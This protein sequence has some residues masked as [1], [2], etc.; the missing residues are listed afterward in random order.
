MYYN[1]PKMS[2][3]L[4]KPSKV[5]V[6]GEM[7][8][9]H[10]GSSVNN[11]K[12]PL[13]L[14]SVV[15]V[16]VGGVGFAARHAINRQSSQ[17]KAPNACTSKAANGVLAQA[18]QSLGPDKVKE[19]GESVNKIKTLKKYDQDPNCLAVL[20]IY[21]INISDAKNARTYYEQL[22]KLYQPTSYDAVLGGKV[23][24]PALMKRTVEFL[25]AQTKALKET[26]AKSNG[27]SNGG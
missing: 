6:S 1:D 2:H 25:E 11:Y 15:L 14:I 10:P 9:S 16:I 8:Q 27:G 5:V 26:P 24:A 18:A 13:I 7:K 19:L 17:P 22:N 3:K 12:R 20:T 23:P 4:K 21:F